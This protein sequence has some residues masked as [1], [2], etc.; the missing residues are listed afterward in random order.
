M[1]TRGRGTSGTGDFSEPGQ[2]SGQS[3]APRGDGDFLGGDTSW[4]DG[5]PPSSPPSDAASQA[6]SFASQPYVPPADPAQALRPLESGAEDT[7]WAPSFGQTADGSGP[8]TQAAQQYSQQS[9]QQ[10]S[11][12]GWTVPS[13]GKLI[14]G[15]G[16]IIAP[17]L[18]FA[19]WW[20]MG[21]HRI[22]IFPAVFLGFILLTG[23]VRLFRRR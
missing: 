3:S 15:L 1:D 9:S 4:R 16:S 17:L 23:V 5:A 10:D 21:G 7:Q 13:A 6:P 11:H 22:G 18:F 19:F 2:A 14:G 12:G 8:E 20:Q